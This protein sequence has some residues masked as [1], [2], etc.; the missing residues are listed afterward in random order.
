MEKRLR[1]Q[2]PP[3]IA[4][5]QEDTILLDMRTIDEKE[6]KDLLLGLRNSLL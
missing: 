4:R 6:E 1:E 5:I 3:I 2:E